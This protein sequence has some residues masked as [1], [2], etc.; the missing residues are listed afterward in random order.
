MRTPKMIKRE[1]EPSSSQTNFKQKRE[2]AHLLAEGEVG[3]DVHSVLIGQAAVLGAVDIEKV[4]SL[5]G[6]GD[7][8][9]AV[10]G[11]H[12]TI[13]QEKGVVVLDEFPD[14]SGRHLFCCVNGFHWSCLGHTA[15]TSKST[16]TNTEYVFVEKS[17]FR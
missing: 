1:E 17:V 6:Q 3:G 16:F 15:W 4:A 12:A 8:A 10:V 5:L 7:V 11:I 2:V 14:Q 9:S 13:L